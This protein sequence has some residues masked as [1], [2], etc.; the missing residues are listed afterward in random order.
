VFDQKRNVHNYTAF[1]VIGI[2]VFTY[3]QTAML[4]GAKS[5]SANI[6][7]TRVLHFPRAVMPLSST[8]IALQRLLYSMI[9]MLPVVLIT[10]EPLAWRWL[11]IIPAIALQS[12]FCLGLAFIVARIGASVPDTSQVLPFLLRTWMYTS[13]ILFSIKNITDSHAHWV[14]VV[15]ELNPGAV[16]VELVREALL[17]QQPPATP[18]VWWVAAGWAVLA[19]VFGYVYFWRAEESYGRV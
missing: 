6:Q 12:L 15:L 16:Y 18:H 4:G 14:R 9:I 5:I 2:F 11:F 1:L 13:G 19:L 17:T 8:L 10:G 7:L 3:T